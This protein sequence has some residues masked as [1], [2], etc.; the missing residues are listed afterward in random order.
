MVDLA[1]VQKVAAVIK[2]ERDPQAQRDA[3][4]MRD[5]WL[6]EVDAGLLEMSAEARKALEDA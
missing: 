2:N 3:L 5:R 4:M 1:N 6:A